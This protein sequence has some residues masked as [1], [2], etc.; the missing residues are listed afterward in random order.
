MTAPQQTSAQ[1]IHARV[2]QT[3]AFFDTKMPGWAYRVPLTEVDVK[4]AKTSPLA[5]I[6][7]SDWDSRIELR[8][9]LE[10]LVFTLYSKTAESANQAWRYEIGQRRNRYREAS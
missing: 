7:G 6:I 3:A 10:W 1:T 8:S 2:A 4:S 9:A 5:W